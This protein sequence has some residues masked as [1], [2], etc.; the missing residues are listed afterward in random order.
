MR[1]IVVL[2]MMAKMPV[3][4]VVWQTLHY[5]LGLRRLGFEPLLRRGARAHAV[6]ADA[7]RRATTAPSA[8]PRF[9]DGVLRRF[10]LGDRW[11][12]HALHD[13]GRC[14]GMS[15]RQLRRAVPRGRADHQPARRHRAAARSW[16]TAAASSTWRPTRCSCRS[17]CTTASQSTRR[18]P[19]GR[20]AP[21]S[22]SPRT[23]ARPTARCRSTTRFRFQ[24]T[25]QPVV[26]DLWEGRGQA[27]GSRFTTVGNWRQPWRDVRFGGERYGWSKDDEWQQVPRPA[28]PHRRRLRAGAERL[29]AGRPPAARRRTAGAVRDALDLDQRPATA[30]TSPA[31][32]PSSPSPRSRTSAS[33][34]GWFSDRSAT[35]LAAGRPVITQDT[36]FGAVLPTGEGLFAVR[37]LDEAVA[38]VEAIEADYARHRRA[39]AEIAREHFDAE[40]VLGRS[41]STSGVDVP[42]QPPRGPARP[43]RQHRATGCGAE[44]VACSR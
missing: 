16:P 32:A 21:S 15:E 20:T 4:G 29:R 42:R 10:G 30:T 36:G 24:P 38:A 27:A 28:R 12:Y 7:A 43:P 26:L 23:S 33:R 3:P 13:D 17:S 5:L 22:R 39:A 14:L 37:D 19:G 44:L 6:D 18:L 34:T 40:R 1:R 8:R 9:I 41:C 35:Y 31:R 25:R 11:A 2:G